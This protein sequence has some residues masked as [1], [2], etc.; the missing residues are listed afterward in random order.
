MLFICLCFII[1][2]AILKPNYKQTFQWWKFYFQAKNLKW[3]VNICLFKWCVRMCVFVSMYLPTP[4]IIYLRNT[5]HKYS[6]QC[7][8]LTGTCF[9]QD[10]YAPSSSLLQDK[11]LPFSPS[12]LRLNIF[13]LFEILSL[14]QLYRYTPE[15]F[16]FSTA[17][18]KYTYRAALR[19][20]GPE[21]SANV[22]WWKFQSLKRIQPLPIR[23]KL[24]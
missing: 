6:D 22:S 21:Y 2:G 12:P 14:T 20:I 23:F 5:N 4:L 18:F 11:Y 10:I 19:R 15:I 16:L 7:S 24:I 9:I 13:R 1:I 17:T 3:N 8:Y